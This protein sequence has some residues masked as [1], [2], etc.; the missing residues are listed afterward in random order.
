MQY[1]SPRTKLYSALFNKEIININISM[2]DFI[3]YGYYDVLIDVAETTN[4]MDYFV[5]IINMIPEIISPK[6]IF[7]SSS[8]K[9][10]DN[11]FDVFYSNSK[12]LN[13]MYDLGKIKSNMYLYFILQQTNNLN[14]LKYIWACEYNKDNT[15]Y[16]KITE[17][18]ENDYFGLSLASLFRHHPT[19]GFIKFFFEL[20]SVANWKF[21]VRYNMEDIIYNCIISNEF[22]KILP[23]I[24]KYII[25][26]SDLLQSPICIKDLERVVKNI[27]YDKNICHF[28]NLLILLKK[29]N[30][31]H[32][33][34]FELNLSKLHY[35]ILIN[36]G[37]NDINIL[38]HNRYYLFSY[39]N[40]IYDV[41]FI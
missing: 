38:K 40:D 26:N 13:K 1:S 5:N 11:E 33:A 9:K 19:Y 8:D 25:S 22:N 41:L 17:K 3:K 29:I 35:K 21:F 10:Y 18:N 23:I 2:N 15:F 39:Y 12:Y 37:H 30:M 7:S 16:T 28:Y 36:Y 6:V 34:N 32:I 31:I 4:D 14:S 24:V 27:Y 20:D